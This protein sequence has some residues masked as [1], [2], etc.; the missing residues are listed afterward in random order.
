MAHRAVAAALALVGVFAFAVSPLV[1]LILFGAALAVLMNH[2]GAFG[3]G[4][5]RAVLAFITALWLGLAGVAASLLGMISTN[6]GGN[7]LLPPGLLLT[8]IGVGLL[9]WSVLAIRRE[10]RRGFQ[11]DA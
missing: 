8:G 1:S 2:R 9:A 5:F 11:V 6:P 4:M 3:S 7:F 10:R